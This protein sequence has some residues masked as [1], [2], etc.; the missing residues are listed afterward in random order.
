MLT[1]TLGARKGTRLGGAG[2]AGVLRDPRPACLAKGAGG[3]PGRLG[4]ARLRVGAFAP[5]GARPPARLRLLGW[6]GGDA[7]MPCQTA[8]TELRAERLC[9]YSPRS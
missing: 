5:R 9:D 4:A 6:L 7:N 8:G 1:D 2:D 3:N